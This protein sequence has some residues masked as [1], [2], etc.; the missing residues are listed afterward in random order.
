MD[1]NQ[2]K[3]NRRGRNLALAAVLAGLIVLFYIMTIVRLG[4]A[5]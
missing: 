3:R 2:F 5:Q 1:A 4:G